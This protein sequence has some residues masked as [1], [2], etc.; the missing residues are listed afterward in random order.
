MTYGELKDA[1]FREYADE[2]GV[3]CATPDE[4]MR[5]LRDLSSKLGANTIVDKENLIDRLRKADYNE[6]CVED[7]LVCMK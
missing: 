4:L 7:V 2:F 6:V 3:I 5:F 1:F